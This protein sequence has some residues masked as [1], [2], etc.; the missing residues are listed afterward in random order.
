MTVR[1]FV[2][3]LAVILVFGVSG[4]AQG[5]NTSRPFSKIVADWNRTLENAQRY[6]DEPVHFE[7][8]NREHRV[9]LGKVRTAAQAAAKNA[10]ADMAQQQQLL[11]ALGPLPKASDPPEP[12]EIEA[13]RAK[14]EADIAFYRARRAQAE[15]AITRAAAL[16]A[17]ISN[18]SRAQLLKDLSQVDPSPLAPDTASRA[19]PDLYRVTR[20]LLR[21][22]VVWWSGLSADLRSSLLFTR[23]P[24]F[25][26]VAF[27]VG[28]GIRYLA[29]RFL[30]RDPETADPT[31]ARRLVGAIADAVS[32][33]IFPAAILTV[34]LIRITSDG[35][36]ITGPFAIVLVALC[37]ALILFVLAWSLP[38][39]ALAPDLPNWRLTV[40]TPTGAQLLSRRITILAALVSVNF[41]FAEAL[42]ALPIGKRLSPEA[43]ALVNF[44]FHVVSAIGMLA[45]LQRRLWRVDEEAA[46]KRGEEDETDPEVSSRRGRFWIAVRGLFAAISIGVVVA[47]AIGYGR[48]GA[49]LISSLIATGLIGGALYLARGL[50][51]ETVA[52][53]L[54]S[55]LVTQK[56]GVQYRTRRLAKFWL[57]AL[58]DVVIFVG[59]VFLIAPAWGVPADELS[60][61]ATQL[62]Q[63]FKVGN[64]TISILDFGFGILIFVAIVLLTRAGQRALT[65]RILPETQIDAGLQHSLSAGFGYIGIVVAAMLGVSAVGL[66]LTNIA[67]IAGALSVGIGFGLQ[68]IV[69]NFVSGITLLIERPIKVGDWVVVG[70]QEGIV[71]R[72]QVR[73]TEIETFQRTSVIVPNSAFLQEPVIN[74]THKDSFGRIEIP[75]GVAYGSDTAKVEQLL[76]DVAKENPKVASWP[77]P[78]VLFQNFGGSSLDFELRCFCP[79]V[80]DT[81]RAGSELRFAIDRVFREEGIE[82]PFP[83]HVVHLKD[84]DRLERLF[85]SKRTDRTE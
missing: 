57:R 54:R 64:V 70:D 27:F 45:I 75:V 6:V 26:V 1:A 42:Q 68:N 53:V 73:A 63:G 80:F 62:F 69:N 43:D 46:R 84:I 40:L 15:V 14:Y 83:Q 65:E 35:A 9:L 47:S 31:Y 59:A 82:I 39:A 7:E 61:W 32:R 4:L 77:E 38:R 72:I 8:R 30:G 49:F 20:A 85:A 3:T 2:S 25:L 5:Q 67:L 78:F 44:F 56:L 16:S 18:L 29:V 52:I 48:L 23:I 10:S 66:D 17:A 13:Q 74:R 24:L 55:A 11:D 50:L 81:F 28:W 51:R 19:L 22:P 41:F 76:L 33:G 37:K 21:T 58:L 60:L 79:N 12:P 36:A 34:V 71:K